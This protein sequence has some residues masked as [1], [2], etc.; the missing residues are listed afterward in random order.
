M[1]YP[2]SL[3]KL[4]GKHKMLKTNALIRQDT[5]KNEL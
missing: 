1:V 3:I 4:F 5:D 2:Y